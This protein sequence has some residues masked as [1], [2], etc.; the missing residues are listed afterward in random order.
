MKNL[1]DLLFGSFLTNCLTWRIKHILVGCL[2]SWDHTLFQ[3]ISNGI[4]TRFSGQDLWD[5]WISLPGIPFCINIQ[6]KRLLRKMKRFFL[7]LQVISFPSFYQLN[8]LDYIEN[9]T[10]NTQASFFACGIM[11]YCLF[12]FALGSCS[13]VKY[14]SFCFF[15][16]S[17][18][19]QL[20]LHSF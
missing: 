19:M 6:Y 12:R 1:L 5:W 16:Y 3:A 18:S 2:L 11:I 13:S 8:V 9:I 20:Y 4:Y 17:S 7:A 15:I 10:R 14:N